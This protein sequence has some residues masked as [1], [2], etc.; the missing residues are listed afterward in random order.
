MFLVFFYSF[1]RVI[2]AFFVIYFLTT[3]VIFSTRQF[4]SFISKMQ[5]FN[6]QLPSA[7][8]YFSG[9]VVSNLFK[10]ADTSI[11]ITDFFGPVIPMSVMY[12]VPFSAFLLFY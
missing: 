12:P 1:H 11:P 5:P 8:L 2:F 10:D 9:S 3:L 4:S 6:M 7:N